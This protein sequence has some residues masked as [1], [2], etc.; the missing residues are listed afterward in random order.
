MLVA[1]VVVLAAVVGQV[2]ACAC[3][4]LLGLSG[5]LSLLVAAWVEWL[6]VQIS[7][8][9]QVQRQKHIQ[10]QMQIHTEI[11]IHIGDMTNTHVQMEL[12]L[13]LD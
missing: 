3:L 4:W 12:Q 5:C 6:P 7:L 9:I 1:V 8:H 13:S 2:V 11:R 10:I